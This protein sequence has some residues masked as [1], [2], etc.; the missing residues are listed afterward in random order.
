[1]T[2]GSR[3]LAAAILLL[4]LNSALLAQDTVTVGVRTPAAP[5]EELPQEVAERVVAFYNAPTTI[6]FSGR[7]RIPEN[8][9]IDGD[10]AI[11]GG[12]VEVAG[13]VSGDMIVANGDITIL[14]TGRIEGDLTVVGGV[15][16]GAED[17]YVSGLITSYAAVFRYRRID[18]GIEYIGSQ[19]R[20][21]T[22]RSRT[23]EWPTWKLGTSEIFVSS[24][25]YNRIEGLPVA[26][27]PRITTSGRNPFRIDALAIFRTDPLFDSNNKLDNLGYQ[28]RL[29]QWLGGRRE[30]YLG[31]GLRSIVG[32]IENWKLSNLENSL[33]LFFFKRDYRDYYERRGWYAHFGWEFSDRAFFGSLEFIDERQ[34]SVA[35]GDP[36]TIFFNTS[37]PFR[38]NAQA[39]AG[40]L[41]SLTLTLGNDTRNTRRRPWSGWNNKVTLEQAVGGSLSG[42]KPDFTHLYLDLRRYLRVSRGS[43]VALR[44]V[45]GGHIAGGRTPVQRQHVIGGAGSLP[46]Y[47]MFQ[48]DCGVRESGRLDEAYG[49]Q[50][51][52][53][54]QAEYRTGLN[55]HWHW[56]RHSTP[57]EIRAAALSVDFDPHIIL[58]YNAGTAWDVGSYWDHLTA[59]D[60]WVADLGAGLAFGGLGFYLAYPLTG[61]GGVNFIL[62]LTERF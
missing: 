48:F 20:E 31:G 19:P 49:C 40:D 17:G 5:G 32:P 3:A 33:A 21:P 55:L 18:D 62:R 4:G 12:P 58:F 50:R 22:R 28:V 16:I 35:V 11:L 10:V 7:T 54:F 42:V 60:N 2:V 46:G 52:A 43:V 59:I 45:G 30:F 38:P 37:D 15:V 26:I 34:D 1:M 8:R 56:D 51:F 23:L 9:R 27:G 13:T 47:S 57:D 36:I 25:A 14:E 41:Q 44:A 61:S 29:T 53:L 24:R 39:D 6:R